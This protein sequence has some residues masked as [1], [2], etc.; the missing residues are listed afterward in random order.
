MITNPIFNYG[1]GNFVTIVQDVI[2]TLVNVFFVIGVVTF[3]FML[4]WGGIQWISSGGEQQK[5]ANAKARVQNALIGLFLLLSTFAIVSIVENV[6]DVDILTINIDSLRIGSGTSG[7]SCSGPNDF[8][9][10]T[11]DCC[12][13]LTCDTA[14]H[15]CY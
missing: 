2:L 5:L 15:L 13:G 14:L 1:S 6:F 11:S 3:F 9:V 7:P 12:S 8:C 10:S 4:V